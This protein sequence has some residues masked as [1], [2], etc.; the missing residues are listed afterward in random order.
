MKIT[1]KIAEFIEI[2]AL[3][4]LVQEFYLYD[5]HPFSDRVAKAVVGL[6]SDESLGSIW[7]I[8][9]RSEPIGYVALMFTYS[10]E[11]HGKIAMID[12]LFLREPYRGQGIGTQTF[13]LIEDF[14]HDRGIHA[15]QLEVERVNTK[16]Q[17][18]YRKKDYKDFDRYLMTKYLS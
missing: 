15:L 4:Q 8:F 2:D 11:F 5:N 10:L 6:L 9:D 7:L 18:F 16:A 12:E 14:C 1:F 3:M 13:K 17:E